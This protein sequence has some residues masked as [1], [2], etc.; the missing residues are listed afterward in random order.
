M[1]TIGGPVGWAQGTASAH[2]AHT[3]QMQRR[4]CA[5]FVK[6]DV[7]L[8]RL[9]GAQALD[10][11]PA[12][13]QLRKHLRIRVQATVDAHADDQPLRQR[14]EHIIESRIGE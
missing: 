12:A 14:I 9:I 6:L 8:D 2:A 11:D 10:G 5:P 3:G 4:E 1:E 7:P 13:F